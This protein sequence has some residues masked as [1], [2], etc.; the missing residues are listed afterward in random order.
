MHN[1]LRVA[2]IDDHPLVR[3][4][5]AALLDG[6]VVDDETVRVCYVGEDVRSAALAEPTVVLLDIHL[7]DESV[8][9]SEAIRISIAAGAHVLL[10]SATATAST[11]LSGLRAGALG[12]IPKRATSEELSAAIS[13]VARGE[14]HLTSDLAAVLSA[15]V[16]RPNLSAQELTALRLYASGLK[17][18]TVARRMDVSPHTVKEYLDRVRSKYASAGRQARTR[19][20]LYAAAQR[21]GLLET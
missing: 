15:D 8:P 3:D 9:L 21:D 10:L 14:V 12:F 17:I 16:E 2:V 4:G 18:A 6:V 20:E 13:E 19:T 5:I 11:V 1:T 7:G